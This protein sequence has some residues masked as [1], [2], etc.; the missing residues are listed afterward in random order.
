MTPSDSTR[1][2]NRTRD[3]EREDAQT[4]AHADREPTSEEEKLA[5][6]NQLDPEAAEHYEEMAERGVNQKGEG[7]ID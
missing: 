1:P 4:K 6:G 7:R 3:A 5:E 2:S